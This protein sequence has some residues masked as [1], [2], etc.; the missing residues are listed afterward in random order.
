MY[1]LMQRPGTVRPMSQRDPRGLRR[2]SPVDPATRI[3]IVD[4]D[5]GVATSLTFMLT[6]RG[7][8]DV[9]AVRSAR[10]AIA[11]SEQFN[12]R[13]VFLDIELPDSGSLAVAEHLRKGVH[14]H[15]LRLIALT[16]SAE[17]ERREEARVAGFER[18]LVKPLSQT[19]LDKILGRPA[20]TEFSQ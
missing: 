4:H 1:Q 9:R 10:R 8:D 17:H 6:A 3:L 12:P 18:F 15:A 11:I 2:G 20:E 19:E 5:R 14:Q 7:Y 13:L 16:N